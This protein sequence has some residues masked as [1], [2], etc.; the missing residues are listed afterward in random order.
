MPTNW[1][2][3][4]RTFFYRLEI[5]GKVPILGCLLVQVHTAKD[6]RVGN[7]DMNMRV[8]KDRRF[9]GLRFSGPH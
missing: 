1:H 3:S 9:T 8:D 7:L 2:K 6:V 5:C 4:I